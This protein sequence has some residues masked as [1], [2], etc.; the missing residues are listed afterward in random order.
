MKQ[1][2]KLMAN[3][4][5]RQRVTVREITIVQYRP[6]R[7]E[8]QTPSLSWPKKKDKKSNC[9][10]VYMKSVESRIEEGGVADQYLNELT[11]ESRLPNKFQGVRW[12]VIRSASVVNVVYFHSL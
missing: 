9:I 12:L 2:K 5:K 8:D 1:A 11:I 6:R 10:Y 7:L 3:I 4:K